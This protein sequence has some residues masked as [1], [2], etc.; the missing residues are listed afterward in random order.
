MTAASGPAPGRTSADGADAARARMA[1]A[2]RDSGRTPS[3]AVQAAFLAVPRHLFVPGLA[4]A[5][6]YQDEALVIKYSDDGLPISSSSQ[7]AMM[8][9]MLEQLGL[10]PG[11]RVLEIGTG[12][13]YNAAV[14]AHI[15]GPRGA[16]V[17]VDIDADLVARAQ[18]SLKVAGYGHVQARCA[19]GGYGDPDGAPFDRVIVTV[20][21]WDIAPA[22]LDQLGPGGRLVLP[23]A[24]R[25][26]QLS[27]ALERRADHHGTDHHGADEHGHDHW[28]STAAFRCGFVRMAG[29]F[30]D[31]ESFRPLRSSPGLYVQADDGRRVDMT[32]LAKALAG[33]TVDIGA[34]IRAGSRDELADLDLWLTLTEPGLDRLT[35]MATAASRGRGGP[36]LPFGALASRGSG[37]DRLGVSGLAGTQPRAPA[38]SPGIDPAAFPGEVVMRGYG[39]GGAALAAH[40]A[41][42]APAWDSL[43]RPGAANLCLTVCPAGADL[44]VAAGQIVLSRPH[45]RLAAGWPVH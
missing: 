11:H 42:Q 14:M 27:V 3:P 28:V 34:G 45:V 2:L 16:V 23:L 43:G 25:A 30:A 38:A 19:D 10:E 22:W 9:I 35:F 33:P 6:A 37:R 39:R 31:P 18:A 20:G 40:L 44:V 29:A 4:P 24:L 8:A 7:P 36:L 26:I 15:V 21:A 13:G 12:T 41:S 32:A 5:A 17:T 1:G